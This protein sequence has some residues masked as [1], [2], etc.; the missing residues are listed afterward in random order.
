MSKIMYGGI[1]Y[2]S[3]VDKDYGWTDLTGILTAGSTS[4][5]IQHEVITT[6]A[7]IEIY[8]DT[9]GV[10]PTN[11]VVTTG[12]IVLTFNAQ[13]SDVGVMV[14]VSKTNNRIGGLWATEL[15]IISTTYTVNS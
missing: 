10:N 14:R 2:G 7:T 8:T 6:T 3:A 5:T 13:A 12:Q 4:L 15:N 1:A 11:A 9:F